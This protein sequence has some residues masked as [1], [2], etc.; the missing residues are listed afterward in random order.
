MDALG[1]KLHNDEIINDDWD[2]DGVEDGLDS[3]TLKKL[4][5]LS[6]ID[7]NLCSTAKIAKTESGRYLLIWEH[8][9]PEMVNFFEC[10]PD[11]PP[12]WEITKDHPLMV[13]HSP[14]SLGNP[15]LAFGFQKNGCLK[16]PTARK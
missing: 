1:M 15:S 3:D 16:M 2:I 6:D 9:H 5:W 14:P 7:A 4:P 10:F 11:A 8:R 13:D 12:P